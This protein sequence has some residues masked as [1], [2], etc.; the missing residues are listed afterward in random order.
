MALLGASELVLVLFNE[1]L[2]RR[3]QLLDGAFA[4]LLDFI[5]LPALSPN[6]LRSE[7]CLAL[8]F[9]FPLELFGLIID[10]FLVNDFSLT[11]LLHK[12]LHF[13]S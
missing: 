3:L 4:N 2:D 1:T 7:P 10:E 12:I 11:T 13:D 6:L 5:S 8:L 9:E